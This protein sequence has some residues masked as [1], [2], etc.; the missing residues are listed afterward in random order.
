MKYTTNL[1]MVFDVP[2]SHGFA[3]Y[4]VASIIDSILLNTEHVT[5]V[6]Y[7]SDTIMLVPPPPPP[8]PTFRFYTYELALPLLGGSLLAKFTRRVQGNFME[9]VEILSDI[10]GCLK[11]L[12]C[13]HASFPFESMDPMNLCK[14]TVIAHG[15]DYRS[16]SGSDAAIYHIA[17]GIVDSGVYLGEDT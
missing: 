9:K 17:K 5:A 1:T 15:L 10:Q 6:T 2:P 12:G 3:C 14:L 16:L 7:D 8:E 4:T 13:L 11:I